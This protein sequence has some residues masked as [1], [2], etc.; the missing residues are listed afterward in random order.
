MC[1]SVPGVGC[2]LLCSSRRG[3]GAFGV[4]G[5]VE[6]SETHRAG[7]VSGQS[8]SV[9]V[10]IGQLRAA[11]T[12]RTARAHADLVIASPQLKLDTR[13]W[14]NEEPH[15]CGRFSVQHRTLPP[16]FPEEKL[17]PHGRLPLRVSGD[18]ASRGGFLS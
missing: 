1:G 13:D 2:C 7:G 5:R 3:T 4:A 10:A 15:L 9:R 12:R 18:G 17:P 8:Y 16:T 11:T 14:A 6:Y